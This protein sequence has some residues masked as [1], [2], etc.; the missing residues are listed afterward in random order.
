MKRPERIY[1]AGS[2]TAERERKSLEH[3]ISLVRKTK[4]DAE[5]FIPME[6]KIED[7]YQNPDGTWHLSNPAWAKR[8]FEMDV[9]EGLTQCDRVIAMY[10]GHHGT[11]GTA[12][13]LGCAYWLGLPITLYIP[14]WAKENNTSLMVLNSAKYWMDE[15]GNEF[16]I[17]FSWLK[18]FNQK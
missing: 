16:P 6:H 1:I 7:D 12:W 15:Y 8:V 13:E 14:E 5:M 17:T 11:T 10:T 2:F 4:P 9:N 18:Q 3:M